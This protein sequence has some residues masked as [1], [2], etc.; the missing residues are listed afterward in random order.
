VWFLALAAL[1]VVSIVGA[2]WYGW[3]RHS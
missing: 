2:L 1:I 3:F